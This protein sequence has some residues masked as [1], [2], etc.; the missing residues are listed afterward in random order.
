[1]SEKIQSGQNEQKDK[2]TD[3]KRRQEH[4]REQSKAEK[5]EDTGSSSNSIPGSGP[6]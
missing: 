5:P 6:G 1:M 4:Q 2:P 3:D